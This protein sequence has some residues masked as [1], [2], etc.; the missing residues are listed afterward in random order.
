[1][2]LAVQS[3][4]GVDN[5]SNGGVHDDVMSYNVSTAGNTEGCQEMYSS[6]MRLVTLLRQICFIDM[7]VLSLMMAVAVCYKSGCIKDMK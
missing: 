5:I 2:V 7:L 6:F 4:G 1:M 3:D